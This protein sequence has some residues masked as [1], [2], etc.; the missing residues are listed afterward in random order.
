MDTGY[1]ILERILRIGVVLVVVFLIL[2][3]LVVLVMAQNDR[4]LTDSR[5]LGRLVEQILVYALVAAGMS[6][7][8]AAGEVDLSVA[9][10]ASLVTIVAAGFIVNLDVPAAIALVAGLVLGLLIGLTNG[11]L[12]VLLRLPSYIITLAMWFLT[13]GLGY[14]LVSARGITLRNQGLEGSMLLLIVL[15]LVVYGLGVLALLLLGHFTSLG[16]LVSL[17]AR[18]EVAGTPGKLPLGLYKIGAYTVSGVLAAV[19]GLALLNL[20]R[21]A[22]PGVYGDL[23]IAAVAV[24]AIGGV[25]L[26]KGSTRLLGAFLGSVALTLA[27]QAATITRLANDVRLI[28]TLVWAMLALIAVILWGLAGWVLDLFFGRRKSDLRSDDTVIMG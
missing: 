28:P 22:L 14:A 9:G 16:K 21:M 19:A 26:W 7:V 27:S 15:N 25:P 17:N 23:T 5:F 18:S 2:A 3:I 8:V 13:A 24:V 4:V 20:N 12:I 6:L 11:L 1:G 10:T